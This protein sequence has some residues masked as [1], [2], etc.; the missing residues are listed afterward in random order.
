MKN[1]KLF[2]IRGWYI[3]LYVNKKIGRIQF[4]KK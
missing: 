4:E 1:L 3:V 2:C